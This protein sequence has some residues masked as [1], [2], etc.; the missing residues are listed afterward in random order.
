MDRD[1]PTTRI[2]KTLLGFI[3][4]LTLISALS[5]CAIRFTLYVV[6][7]EEFENLTGN[8]PNTQRVLLERLSQNPLNYYEVL[9]IPLFSEDGVI[10]RAYR[11]KL[12]Q[13][14]PDKV[15]GGKQEEAANVEV[16]RVTEAYK[17]L[18]SQD[19]C[20]YD[21]SLGSGIGRF[22]DCNQ[23]WL[24]RKREELAEKR[25][26][27]KERNTVTK[28]KNVIADEKTAVAKSS[29][30]TRQ[31][32]VQTVKG[33]GATTKAAVL[34]VAGWFIVHVGRPLGMRFH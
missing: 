25:K 2:F 23:R 30:T 24:D 19:R 31:K 34:V 12:K 13:V 26:E 16:Q 5:F 6:P 11:E 10:R 15:Q 29:M 17:T 1:F 27:A 18:T 21:F 14:H 4:T 8:P 20:M 28:E 32:L 22:A 9:E 7:V 3:V 33:I